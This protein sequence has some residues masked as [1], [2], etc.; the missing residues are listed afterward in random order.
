MTEEKTSLQFGNCST[1]F[2]NKRFF[3]PRSSFE[4]YTELKNKEEN[5]YSIFKQMKEK[6]KKVFSKIHE[7]DSE[8]QFLSV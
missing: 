8:L 4:Q 5:N 7:I 6:Q 1:G 3:Y 2:S